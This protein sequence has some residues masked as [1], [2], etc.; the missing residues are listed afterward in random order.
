VSRKPPRLPTPI[1]SRDEAL[2]YLEQFN[3]LIEKSQNGDLST[4]ELYYLAEKFDPAE[5]YDYEQA[6]ELSIALLKQWL[7]KYKFKNW[8]VT[9]TTKTPVTDDMKNARAVEIAQKLN[10]TK[11]WHSHGR[12]ISM[13][14]LTDHLKLRIEDFGAD[15]TLSK[16]IR[17]YHGFMKDYMS[18]RDH[19]CV[20]HTNGRYNPYG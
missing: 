6:R 3:R 7:V 20:L 11:H 2:G 17:H 19:S 5:L 10:D 9:E 13:H 12:C 15:A 16:L 4:A 18:R 14:E 8:T 1:F